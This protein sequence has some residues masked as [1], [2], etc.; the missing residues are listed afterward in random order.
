MVPANELEGFERASRWRKRVV[1][2]VVIAG[3]LA[4]AAYVGLRPAE[5]KR[6]RL[7]NF[8]LP[9]LSGTGS[10]SDEGLEGKPVV[11]NFWASWC[12]PC[13]QETPLLESTYRA[14]RDRGVEFVGV[15]IRDSEDDAREFLRDFD[16]TYPVVSDVD[17][18][19]ARHLDVFGL[20]QTFF[21]DGDGF[22][23]GG[24]AEE[25]RPESS[26]SGLGRPGG[27]GTLGT[28]SK[29]ELERGIERLLRDAPTED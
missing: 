19:L 15:N 3:A 5:Q 6:Q 20:P 25:A 26:P 9:L 17:Q 21:V 1:V 18:V 11:L 22:I 12:D 28:I 29:E 24:S 10:L 8:T 27:G 2:V 4:I 14:Y 13:R 7:P 23:R 16:V